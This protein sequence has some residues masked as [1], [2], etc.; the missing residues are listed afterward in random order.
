MGNKVTWPSGVIRPILS[1]DRVNQRFASGPAVI[2]GDPVE[3]G[4]SVIGVP[5]GDGPPGRRLRGAGLS[6]CDR[7]MDDILRVEVEKRIGQGG[8][9]R[10]TVCRSVE[11]TS[12]NICQPGS[13]PR[14]RSRRRA[15]RSSPDRGSRGQRGSRT[16]RC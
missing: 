2:P 5:G 10:Y 9:V 1:S 16:H 8:E 6:R 12:A 11:P 7:F 15:V 4:N 14:G 3:M 13:R